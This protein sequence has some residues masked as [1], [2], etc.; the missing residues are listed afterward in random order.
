MHLFVCSAFSKKKKKSSPEKKQTEETRPGNLVTCNYVRGQCPIIAS[1]KICVFI[2]FKSTEQQA[3][4][5]LYLDLY[6]LQFLDKMLQKP[7]NNSLDMYCHPH[8]STYHYHI[9]VHCALSYY[10]AQVEQ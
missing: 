9:T 3:I 8:L 6:G 2:R 10:C 4:V 7:H 5:T 1:H